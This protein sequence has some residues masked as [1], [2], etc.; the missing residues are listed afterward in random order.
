MGKQRVKKQ[1]GATMAEKAKHPP[2]KLNTKRRTG[3][4]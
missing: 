3:A 2:K 4:K 1:T